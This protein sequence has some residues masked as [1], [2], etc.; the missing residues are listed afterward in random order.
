M[1]IL[2]FLRDPVNY[3]V[4]SLSVILAVLFSFGLSNLLSLINWY[5]VIAGISA[6]L[7]EVRDK[8]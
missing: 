6:A 7:F 4:L 1:A 5:G 2:D 8:L 3:K